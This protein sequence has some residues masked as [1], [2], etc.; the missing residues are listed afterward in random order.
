VLVDED[1]EV[2]E[3][4]GRFLDHA[5]SNV[6]EYTGLITGLEMALV[7]GFRHVNVIMDSQLVVCQ[8]LGKYQVKHPSMKELHQ[9]A[10]ALV[11]R[12]S[13]VSF[14]HVR[15]ELNTLADDHVNAIFKERATALVARCHASAG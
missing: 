13:A 6:A 4:G 7:R 14:T 9:K 11:E 8:M 15:R 10:T 1:G 3:K 2:I 12:F 5:T